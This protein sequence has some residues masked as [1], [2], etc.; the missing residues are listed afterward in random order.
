MY[1][2]VI[3]RVID[4]PAVAPHEAA[5]SAISQQEP[6][7]TQAAPEVTSAEIP[8]EALV[9]AGGGAPWALLGLLCE[10]VAAHQVSHDEILYSAYC[11]IRQVVIVPWSPC[12]C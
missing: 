2:G 8:E 1:L 7:R 11:A 12:S 5:P 6:V 3:L 4:V 9:Q 10:D